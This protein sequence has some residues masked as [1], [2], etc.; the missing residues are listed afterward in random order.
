[1][2]AGH[3]CLLDLEE[4][5]TLDE[6]GNQPAWTIGRSLHLID[7]FLACLDGTACQP[8]GSV[9]H[10]PAALHGY[11]LLQPIQID[12]VTFPT[13]S[14]CLLMMGLLTYVKDGLACLRAWQ[15]GSYVWQ[16]PFIVR[17]PCSGG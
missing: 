4:A 13:V 9:F 3:F 15:E 16:P 17:L 11:N 5:S 10:D 12:S 7:L 6:D 8:F 2:D 1:M 14:F